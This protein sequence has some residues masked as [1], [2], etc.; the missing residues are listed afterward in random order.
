MGCLGALS[1]GRLK[2]LVVATQRVAV[3]V[4]HA[5][6]VAGLHQVRRGFVPR[7]GQVEVLRQR[8]DARVVLLLQRLGCA[9]M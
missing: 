9:Q 2:R 6:V 7:A 4:Y 1:L 3:G 8:F 5:R